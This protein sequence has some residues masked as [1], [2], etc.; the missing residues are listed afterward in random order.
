MTDGVPEGL[1]PDLAERV[2]GV[3]DVPLHR[4]LGFEVMSVG[5]GVSR[6][7]FVV[8]P[9]AINNVGLIHGGVLYSLLDAACYLAVAGRLAADTTAST[10]DIAFSML[11]PASAGAEVTLTAALDRLGRSVAFL[12]GEAWADGKLIAKAQATKA[13][14]AVDP[15]R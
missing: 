8:G 14:L 7:R 9:A 2:A 3:L 1:P 12:H 15:P 13:I 5:D 10:I 4:H 11:R 6:A